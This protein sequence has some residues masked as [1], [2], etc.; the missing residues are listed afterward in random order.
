MRLAVDDTTE[1]MLQLALDHR[2]SWATNERHAFAV[3]WVGSGDKK[4]T[5]IYFRSLPKLAGFKTYAL[6]SQVMRVELDGKR[7][8]L[9]QGAWMYSQ[10][11]GPDR[12][13]C[14]SADVNAWTFPNVPRAWRG[15]LIQRAYAEVGMEEEGVAAAA[16]YQVTL[17]RTKIGF[18]SF[19]RRHTDET[20]CDEALTNGFI[21]AEKHAQYIADMRA[22][23]AV[24]K[25]KEVTAP[26]EKVLTE[27]IG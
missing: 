25:R 15:W 5:N 12:K 1:K 27:R 7:L 23:K 21:T 16:A 9:A 26:A 3:R 6:D 19:D 2:P 17:E 10:L 18:L 8:P 20:L 22:I 24:R 11:V 13:M 4:P 14:W